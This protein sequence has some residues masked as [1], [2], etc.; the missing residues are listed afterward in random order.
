[1]GMI[2]I[3]NVLMATWDVGSFLQNLGNVLKTWGSY[4]VTII[5]VIMV[6]AAAYQIAKGLIS[7]GKTQTNWAVTILLLIIGGALMSIGGWDL[8]VNVAQG[9]KTTIENIG[10]GT[11]GGSEEGGAGAGDTI[12]NVFRMF[13]R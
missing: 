7:H 2:E 6:I 1:M 8:L 5:G 4:I 13:S 3:G 10:S 9:G 11:A 12:L